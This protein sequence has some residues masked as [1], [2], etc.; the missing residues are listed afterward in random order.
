[1]ASASRSGRPARHALPD[2]RGDAAL[3]GEHLAAVHR[4]SRDGAQLVDG[5][6]DQGFVSRTNLRVCLPHELREHILP[7][8][9]E[10][11]GVRFDDNPEPRL[12]ECLRQTT[13]TRRLQAEQT[14][15]GAKRDDVFAV[16][17]DVSNLPRVLRYNERDCAGKQ[18]VRRTSA[19]LEVSRGPDS[20]RAPIDRSAP[21]SPGT[22]FVEGRLVL[23]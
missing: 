12:R 17:E 21:W 14:I 22:Q 9:V 4:R 15:G 1:R 19:E 20:Q 8:A 2:V 3:E 16:D 10:W 18:R 7:F 13:G 6:D 23:P 5:R 11:D